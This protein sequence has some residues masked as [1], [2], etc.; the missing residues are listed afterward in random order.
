MT[1]V[2]FYNH[3]PSN[4]MLDTDDFFVGWASSPNSA[5]FRRILDASWAVEV[6]VEQERVIG[7]VNAISDGIA[8]AFIPWLEVTPAKQGQGIGSTLMSRMTARLAH[9]YSIDLVCDDDVLS[10]YTKQGWIG[11]RGAGLRNA[12]TFK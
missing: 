6:A 2:T 10:Y 7:F 12:N 4:V 3:L 5:M 1:I 9:L 11:M 8:T